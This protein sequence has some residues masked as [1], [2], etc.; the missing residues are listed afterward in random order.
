VADE[1]EG[2]HVDHPAVQPFRDL[3]QGT[4]DEQEALAAEVV[5]R[6]GAT[7]TDTPVTPTG[8]A[9]PE[10]AAR[11]AAEDARQRKDLPSFLAARTAEAR[12]AM[13]ARRQARR[14]Q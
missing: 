9:D 7:H 2:R 1:Y 8:S 12:A 4:P 6:V 11:F 14:S 5:R 13:E 3:I 10:Q